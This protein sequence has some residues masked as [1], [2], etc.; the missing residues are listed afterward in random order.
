MS[1]ISQKSYKNNQTMKSILIFINRFGVVNILKKSNF[2]KTKGIS[3]RDMLIYLIQLVYTGKTMNM[4]YTLDSNAPN[5][6]KD[7]IYRFLNSTHINWEKFLLLLSSTIIRNSVEKLTSED[8]LNAIVI[9]DSFY[10]RTRSKTVE[11]LSNVFDHASKGTK[12]KRGFRML[13]AGWTDGNSFIPLAFS[14]Q[15]SE[16]KKNRYTEMNPNL[17][18]NSN[19]YKRR[20]KAITK[21]TDVMIDMLKTIVKQ[22]VSAKHVLF[23]SWFAYPATIIKISVIKL[24]TIARLKKTKNIKYIFE[25]E[26]KTL[27][28]I[29]KSKRKRPGRSKYLLSVLVK[30][31]NPKGDI[32]DAKIVFVRDRNNK[33]NWIAII[34]TDLKLTAEDVIAMYGK[35]WSIEVFFKMCKSY[36]NLSKEFQGISYDSMVS[37][38]SI[39][40]V[41]YMIL[42]VENRENKDIRSIGELF[43]ITCDELQDITFSESLS[44]ILEA[45]IETLQDML[46]LTLI[47]L[48]DLMEVFISK[49]PKYLIGKLPNTESLLV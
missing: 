42:S 43:F 28:Q 21:S 40:M 32:L 47:Q 44:I 49:L 4:N 5:F 37:H 26:L 22:G 38:T 35:R 20:K 1:S 30:I 3:I 15:S 25:D 41:R 19:G 33:K 31:K 36:L 14:L 7:V 2:Y 6:K 9:D 27:N 45:F 46:F 24:H 48:N 10:G 13:T 34:S 17:N 8:R 29:Y 39:V 16:N 12:Y 18:K 23:D 11:L